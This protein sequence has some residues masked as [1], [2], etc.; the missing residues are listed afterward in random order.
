MKG[1]KLSMREIRKILDYRLEKKLSCDK[2][3]RVLQKSKGVIVSTM[4]RFEVSGLSWPLPETLSDSELERALYPGR[5]VLLS[6]TKLPVLEYINQKLNRP[7]M[8]LQRL[9]EEYI[10][11]NPA[12]LKRSNFFRYVKKHTP[13][14]V[15]MR[16]EQKGGDVLYSDYSKDSYRC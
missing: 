16:H 4:R 5:T 13:L 12:G 8:T 10:Q 2:T 1:Q 6:T 9:F 7:H 15:T 11:E 3:A 14:D